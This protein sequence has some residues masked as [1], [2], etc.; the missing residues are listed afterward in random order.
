MFFHADLDRILGEVM[1]FYREGKIQLLPNLSVFPA[2]EISQAFEAFGKK[3]RI[4]RVVVSF[5]TEKINVSRRIC[6][7]QFNG[8]N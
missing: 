2:S 8:T 4:G 5:D 7:S 1:Q 6:D 3:D